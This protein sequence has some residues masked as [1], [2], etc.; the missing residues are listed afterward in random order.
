MNLSRRR[1]VKTTSSALALGLAGTGVALQ[2]DAAAQQT[3]NLT[4]PM[5]QDPGQAD[6]EPLHIPGILSVPAGNTLLLRAYGR[7]VQTYTCP[8]SPTSSAV[9]HAI[10]LS[11]NRAGENIVA[12]HFAG[13]T[14][15]ALDGSLVAGNAGKATH[16][17]SPNGEGVDWLLIPAQSMSGSGLFSNVTYI[18]RL[19]TQGGKPPASCN[20]NQTE[21]LVE[22]SAEYLFYIPKTNSNST[23]PEPEYRLFS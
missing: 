3:S 9:P 1:F 11:G 10:L 14:W 23:R 16:F 17:P 6:A 18:Q 8:V 7:G 15:Q 5:G 4:T 2:I 22:Y 19:Y 20:Q 21:T 13:P 12:I